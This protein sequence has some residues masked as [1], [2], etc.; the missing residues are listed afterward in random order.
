MNYQQLLQSMR[1][2]LIQAHAEISIDESELILTEGER[3]YYERDNGF[4]MPDDWFELFNALNGLELRWQIP[5]AHPSLTG[6]FQI[7]HFQRFLENDSEDR[8][9]VDWYE[10]EDINEIKKHRVL[11]SIDGDDAYITVKFEEDGKYN[12]YYVPE[13][14]VNFGGSKELSRIPLDLS[15]YVQLVAG[16]FG[17]YSVRRHLHQEEF[18]RNPSKCIPEYELLAERIPGFNPPRIEPR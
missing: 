16:Y 10:Q 11:E 8:L 9:W 15:Q 6:F 2:E 3:K 13:G 5:G 1:N 18:Y 4:Y 12:L 17:V 7:H 14:A